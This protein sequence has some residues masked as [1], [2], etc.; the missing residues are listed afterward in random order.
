[1]TDR[2]HSLLVVLEHDIREDEGALED[3]GRMISMIRG[4]VSV[5]PVRASPDS[6]MAEQRAAYELRTKIANMLR[7]D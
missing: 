7:G 3:I 1:M 6:L 2:I 4:V 5:K